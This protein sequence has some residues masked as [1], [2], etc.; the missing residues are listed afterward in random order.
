MNPFTK[1]SIT[2]HP[3]FW[4]LA[5]LIGWLS[6][7][8]IAGTLIWMAVVFF[9]VLIHEYG[10]ALTALAF[11]Q[12]ARIELMG[13]GGLTYRSGKKLKF[14][15]EFLVVL[16][17][18][19]A[20]F[21]LFLAAS[22][23]LQ[24][25]KGQ[26]DNPWYYAIKITAFA[27]LF[28]T[29]VNLLP[30]YP[31]DGGRLFTIILE[32]LFGIKGMKISYFLSILFAVVI[33]L[34][35]FL[36]R[37]IFAG[38]IFMLLAFESYRNWKNSLGMTKQDQ[39]VD[40]QENLK[41]AEHEVALGKFDEAVSHFQQIREQSKDGILFVTATEYLARIF[42]EQGKYQEAYAY[43]KEVKDH[44]GNETLLLLQQLAYQVGELRQAISIGNKLYQNEP[45]FESALINA[46]SHSLLG[47]VHPAVGW[48]NSAIQDGLPNPK[49]VLSKKEFDMIRGDV[50]F[51]ELLN[52]SV[53][54]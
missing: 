30:V 28:W 31:L 41:K 23:L 38:A 11:G 1:I 51:Q 25:L 10:H 29:I 26:P 17:G 34:G 15:Q 22:L 52:R 48:L 27:N 2:I 18:P 37:Q 20:G 21:L 35:F 32:S 8:T 44:L 14:W 54:Q 43:L 13:L 7:G 6:S 33:S 42:T 45:S 19:I 24:V 50:L 12:N 4:M 46:F 9:S 47:E 49:E 3:V 5:G 39:N 36:V 40:L 16:N 53:S